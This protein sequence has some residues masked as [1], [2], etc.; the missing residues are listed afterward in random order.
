MPTIPQLVGPDGKPLRVA[1][2]SRVRRN[3]A[4]L[5]YD[6]AQV[7]DENKNHWANADDL[8]AREANS[9]DVRQRL[10]R[11][12]RYEVA[13]NCYASGMVETL[14]HDVV[15]TGPRPSSS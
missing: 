12:A 2:P 15:G 8:S 9:P 5:R 6:S 4:G 7:T 10:R 14:G 13:N 1:G 3:A 11:N